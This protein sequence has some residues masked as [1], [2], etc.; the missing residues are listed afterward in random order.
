M[1]KVEGAPFDDVAA[2]SKYA[3]D[4]ALAKELG[5]IT[6]KSEQLFDPNG[7]ITR[8]D[9]AVIL[10]KVMKLIDRTADG[11]AALLESFR[12]QAS[13]SSYAKASVAL[14]VKEQILQGVSETK[15]DPQ[16]KVTKAQAVVAVMRLLDNLGLAS[17]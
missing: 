12:D 8:Q 14:L 7:T 6:G 5:I 4:I 2:D 16:A 3:G 11:D 9:M 1:P 10:A 17:K 13:I 15:F